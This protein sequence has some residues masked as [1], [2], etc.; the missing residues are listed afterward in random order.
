MTPGRLPIAVA[1]T[2]VQRYASERAKGAIWPDRA[3]ENARVRQALSEY[4][5]DLSR[6]HEDAAPVGS[7]APLTRGGNTLVLNPGVL[8]AI[9]NLAPV[10]GGLG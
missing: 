9:P 1:R 10:L 2:L 6:A 7:G 5:Y 3:A 8:G 4:Y